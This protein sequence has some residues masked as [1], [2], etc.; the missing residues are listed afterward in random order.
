M[1]EAKENPMPQDKIRLSELK[2]EK[3]NVMKSTMEE[4]FGH[5][6][7]TRLRNAS[8]SYRQAY[9]L[10][11][12]LLHIQNPE[13]QL[14]EL[15]QMQKEDLYEAFDPQTFHLETYRQEVEQSIERLTQQYFGNTA[16]SN[17]INEAEKKILGQQAFDAF[18][19]NHESEIQNGTID[20]DALTSYLSQKKCI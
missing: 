8:I 14:K 6:I 17:S 13:E 2:N 18:K 11:G 15:L 19:K 4:I 9:Q 7:T 1:L 10:I 3:T 5:A 12:S 20:I 16:I